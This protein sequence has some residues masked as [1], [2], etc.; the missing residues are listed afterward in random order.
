MHEPRFISPWP[1]I[2][3]GRAVL[4]ACCLVRT[5]SVRFEMHIRGGQNERDSSLLAIGPTGL[6]L[7]PEMKMKTSKTQTY[8][9]SYLFFTLAVLTYT[10]T[11]DF[12]LCPD[13]EQLSRNVPL[14]MPPLQKP[15]QPVPTP[16]PARSVLTSVDCSLSYSM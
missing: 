10:V 2:R 12:Y 13:L 1:S 9:R 4:V 5:A 16:N 14:T 8:A 7:L 15:G 11:I 3:A 6:A